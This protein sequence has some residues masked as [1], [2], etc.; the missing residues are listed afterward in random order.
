V[1]R[2]WVFVEELERAGSIALVPDE[3]RHVAARRLRVGD[4]LVVFDGRGQ[5]ALA[6]I[7]SL[8]KSSVVVVVDSIMQAERPDSAFVLASAIPKGDRLSTMLQMLTQLGLG[9]WQP[10]VLED[11]AVR[12]LD[13]KSKRLVRILIES[14]KVSRRPWMLDVRE[15][16]SLE[17]ALAGGSSEAA[18][19]FGD[20]EGDAVGSIAPTGIVLIGPEAGFSESE[21]VVLRAL[22]AQPRS[23]GAHNLRIETA[24]VAATVALHLARRGGS[25]RIARE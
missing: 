23:F 17:D 10:L 16:C 7:E 21:R 12:K 15:P 14:C 1:S 5:T 19:Y 25:S 6:R 20:R 3:A 4:S 8:A 22:G 11:S 18:I 9:S 24:A 2:P 13:P